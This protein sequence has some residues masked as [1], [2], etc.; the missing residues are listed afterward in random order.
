MLNS[1]CFVIIFETP[2]S[3]IV[4]TSYPFPV[5]MSLCIDEFK[6]FKANC[7]PSLTERPFL[8]IASK[9]PRAKSDPEPSEV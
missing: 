2:L 4:T 5:G 7:T 9:T 6:A 1:S 3:V 8:Y